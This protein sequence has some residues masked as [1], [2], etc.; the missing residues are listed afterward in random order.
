MDPRH[1]NWDAGNIAVTPGSENICQ[2]ELNGHSSSL[3]GGFTTE[4][5]LAYDR[6][7]RLYVLQSMTAPRG[8]LG[9]DHGGDTGMIVRVDRGGTLT[10]VAT[11]LIFPRA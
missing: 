5:S 11:G 9:P 2:L 1:P 4:Q 8:L 3:T 10:T 7:G 6:R